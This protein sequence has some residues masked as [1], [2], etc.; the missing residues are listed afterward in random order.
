MHVFQ[1]PLLYARFPRPALPSL[2][3]AM[4][5]DRCIGNALSIVLS[6]L[7]SKSFR[8]PY[9]VGLIFHLEGDLPAPSPEPVDP[10]DEP[11]APTPDG[12]GTSS[13]RNLTVG[14]IRMKASRCDNLDICPFPLRTD[15]AHVELAGFGW[16][17]E[18]S[19]P[20]A[21]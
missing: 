7:S 5:L 14:W 2:E 12:D 9:P 19:R 11:A 3:T 1:A 8:G 21:Y 4:A 6:W 15:G 17:R 20:Y 10:T 13:A 16:G 18:A